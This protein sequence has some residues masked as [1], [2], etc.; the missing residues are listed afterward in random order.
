ML[1]LGVLALNYATSYRL[2]ADAV[3]INLAARQRMLSQRMCKALLQLDNAARAGGS[4]EPARK[5]LQLTQELYDTTLLAF[6]QSGTVVGGENKPVFLPAVET[7]A[8]QELVHKA[9]TLWTPFKDALQPILAAR[10]QID[11]T[12]LAPALD[13]MAAH[14]LGDPRPRQFSDHR[15]G[16]QR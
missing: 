7:S 14:N 10:E 11:P 9:Q 12:M 6:A 8:G 16:Q 1:D 13:Y 4:I 5:E 3:G 2:A 15:T